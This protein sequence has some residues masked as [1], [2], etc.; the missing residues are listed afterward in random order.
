M[1]K[2]ATTRIVGTQERFDQ[3]KQMHSFAAIGGLGEKVKERWIQE[4]IDPFRRIFYPETRAINV[5]MRSWRN[6]A[7]GPYVPS[8]PEL[9]IRGGCPP[10][11]KKSGDFWGRILS[12][13]VS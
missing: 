1:K 8:K 7:D 12:A 4:S 3:R 2:S 13:Y 5:S 9:T 6:V 11:S 10:T